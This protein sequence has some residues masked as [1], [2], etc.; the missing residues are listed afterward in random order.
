MTEFAV[1]ASGST[2]KE[3]DSESGLDYFGARY[4]ASSMGRFLSPD[5]AAVATPAPYAK[6]DDPQS[7]N[8]YAY[9]RNNPL[10]MFD[11]DG[12]GWWRDFGNGLADSTYRPFVQIAKHPIA[13]AEGIGTAAAHPIVTG[14]A[15]GIGVKDTVVAAAHGNGRAIG[16]IVGTVG[17][18]LAGGAVARGAG[19]AG[20]V[21][22]EAGS[23][24]GET[25]TVTTTETY[26]IGRQADTAAY[27]G[28]EGFNV[29]DV[30]QSRWTPALN[31]TWIQSGIDKSA[32]FML[33][34]PQTGENLFSPQ[35]G[36]TVFAT[37]MDQLNS[38][39]YTMVGNT[40][41]PPGVK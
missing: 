33:C 39:G 17:V 5:W 29:L 28:K 18:A 22:A 14:K 11:P 16:Q 3:R 27:L 35:Y 38:A 1:C 9:V 7:L 15:I 19:A 31:R 34:S 32:C 41:V 20:E 10:Y 8:L 6:L 30:P 25:G 26:V 12:H 2:D 37:E 21:G 24:V 36:R 23:F 13:T 40:M 4:Y